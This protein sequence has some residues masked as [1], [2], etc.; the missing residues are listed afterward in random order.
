MLEYL[1]FVAALY[2]MVRA[3]R[4]T[5]DSS[6][7]LSDHYGIS[8]L[9]FGFVIVAVFVSLPDLTIASLSALKGNAPLG[10]GDALGS[11]VANICLVIGAATVFRRIKIDRSHVVDSAEMLLII[12]LIPLILLVNGFASRMEGLVLVTVFL[13]YVFLMMKEKITMKEVAPMRKRDISA[14]IGMFLAGILLTVVSAHFLTDA[15][16]TIALDWGIPSAVVGLTIVAFGTTIPE[17]IINFTAVRRGEVAL[18]IGEIL[19]SS[20]VNLTL[21]LGSAF[22]WSPVPV[23]FAYFTLPV[24]FIVIANSLLAYYFIKHEAVGRIQGAL[25]LGMYA[26]FLV[27]QVIGLW[28]R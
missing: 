16:S 18:A 13:F 5:I 27:A 9:A 4:W 15:A 23:D 17:L 19:G 24:A 20:V 6:I 1:V 11:T 2:I 14:L 12:S 7:R 8:R 26:V 25:F 3:S 28:I 21:V 22:F 10:V